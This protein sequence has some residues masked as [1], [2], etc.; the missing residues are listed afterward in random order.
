[1]DDELLDQVVTRCNLATFVYTIMRPDEAGDLVRPDDEDIIPLKASKKGKER[2]HDRSFNDLQD[3]DKRN[4]MLRKAWKRFWLV[5]KP[6][7][8]PVNATYIELWL[9]F[10]SQVRGS[11][12]KFMAD[13]E[14][15]VFLQI[16]LN[17]GASS[18]DPPSNSMINQPTPS[19]LVTDIFAE[20]APQRYGPEA[21]DDDIVTTADDHPG[22]RRH[23]NG[24]A[25]AAW[26][27]H[28]REERT[29]VSCCWGN[30]IQTCR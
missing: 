2:A 1:M 6:P 28:A 23:V 9:N 20:D 18:I 16:Y 27:L 4:A 24:S 21:D 5:A 22:I 12:D 19:R 26:A 25:W 8:E 15:T 3:I 29:K 10:A 7:T 30:R 17:F 14:L 11:G 13:L